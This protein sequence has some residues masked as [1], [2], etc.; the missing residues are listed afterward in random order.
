MDD[1][2]MLK[3]V[4]IE[5]IASEGQ[6]IYQKIKAQ[7]EPQ[8]N[9]KY[10]AIEVESKKVFLAQT[11]AEAVAKALKKFPKKYF[12]VLKIGFTTAESIARYYF[13]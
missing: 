6:K 3:K 13:K 1:D 8:M 4:N 10:L 7:Y 12:F 5:K 11:G 2:V 9:G